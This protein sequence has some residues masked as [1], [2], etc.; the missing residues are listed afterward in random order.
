MFQSSSFRRFCQITNF[1]VRKDSA[2]TSRSAAV[3]GSGVSG[4]SAAAIARGRM[5][6]AESTRVRFRCENHATQWLGWWSMYYTVPKVRARRHWNFA[7]GHVLF[8]Y[9][10]YREAEAWVGPCRRAWEPRTSIYAT[11]CWASSD[12]TGSV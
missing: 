7:D 10:N 3:D 4:R 11:A 12:T 9:R 2:A 6:I 8:G 5:K 1:C